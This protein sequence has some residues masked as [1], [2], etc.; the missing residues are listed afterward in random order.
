MIV[1]PTLRD[2]TSIGFDSKRRNE[3]F[4]SAVP[5]GRISDEKRNPASPQSAF[6][7][8][9]NAFSKRSAVL[10][11]NDLNR[12]INPLFNTRNIILVLN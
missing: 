7:V 2:K 5:V 9:N 11:A 12:H 6:F 8:G 4:S 1:S 10:L 3:A